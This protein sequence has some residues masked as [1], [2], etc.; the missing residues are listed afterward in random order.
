[1]ER[2]LKFRVVCEKCGE[3]GT[4]SSMHNTFEGAKKAAEKYDR[5]L[6]E[7]SPTAMVSFYVQ[8]KNE[9][10]KYEGAI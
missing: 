7:H 4:V 8:E 3:T 1:M 9:D 2:K 5:L 10:G 6:R